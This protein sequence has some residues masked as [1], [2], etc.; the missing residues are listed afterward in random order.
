M[1][2]LC[3]VVNLH[4][5]ISGK[6]TQL[7]VSEPSGKIFNHGDDYTIEYWCT[8]SAVVSSSGLHKLTFNGIISVGCASCHC[9]WVTGYHT[10]FITTSFDTFSVCFH[11]WCLTKIQNYYNAFNPSYICIFI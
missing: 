1:K 7:W 4:K 9:C 2:L 3:E 5:D 6:A 8:F 10:L 11:K